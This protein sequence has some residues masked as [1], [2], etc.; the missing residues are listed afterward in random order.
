MT[1]DPYNHEHFGVM[2]LTWIELESIV[3]GLAGRIRRDWNPDI[4]VGIAKGGVIP[5]AMISSA[6]RIDFVPIK[7]SS[8]HNEAIISKEPV[9]HVYPPA[10]SVTGKNVLLVDDICVA[11][12][13]FSMAI[14]E[15]NMRGA[16]EVRT[17]SVAIHEDSVKPDY[18][19]LVSD[20]CIIWPWERDVLS[21]DG[22]WV[23]NPDYEAE[24]KGE[25]SVTIT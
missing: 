24:L 1:I 13:T 4:V 18:A 11:G 8:R 21:E 17:A 12:R 3:R 22:R 7:L 2:D 5:G 16:A 6:F 25:K 15:L 9:W 19:G 14:E 10:S 23:I 20:A